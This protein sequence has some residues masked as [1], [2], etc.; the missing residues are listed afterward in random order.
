MAGE[1]ALLQSCYLESLKIAAEHGLRT[2]ALPC[3]STGAFGYPQEQAC[4]I[5]VQTVLDWIKSNDLPHEIVFCCYGRS[6]HDIHRR[7]LSTLIKPRS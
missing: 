2:I 6:D 3:I 4:R 7:I 1:A 5:A